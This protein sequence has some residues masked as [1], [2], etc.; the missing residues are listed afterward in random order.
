M[1]K[2]WPEMEN[3]PQPGMGEKWPKMVKIMGFGAI[4]QFCTIFGHVF[5][6]S[7]H[8]PFCIFRPFFFHVRISARF[9][10]YTR[11]SVSQ[12][13]LSYVFPCV[14]SLLFLSTI[15]KALTRPGAGTE[16]L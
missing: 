6:I 11:R 15:G 10:F 5:P 14:S 7:G 16:G 9:P 12:D 13:A 2:N 3:G 1:G 8:G 4:F